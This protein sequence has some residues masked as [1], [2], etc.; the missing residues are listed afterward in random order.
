MLFHTSKCILATG[1]SEGS[2]RQ[3]WYQILKEKKLGKVDRGRVGSGGNKH[4]GQ[5][6]QRHTEQAHASRL[7]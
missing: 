5:C 4:Q 6:E 1:E 7:K 2:Q 3:D